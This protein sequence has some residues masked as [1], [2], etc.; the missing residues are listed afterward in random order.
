MSP[1]TTFDRRA[2]ELASRTAAGTQV[3]LLWSKRTG[4]AAV[5]VYD[6]ATGE[7]FELLVRK[8]DNPLDL[9][10]HPYAY[11]A[12]RYATRPAG[13]IGPRSAR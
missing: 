3:T 6:E 12:A 10:Y 4:R 9:Y 13:A 8:D 2:R 7:S 5:V 1:H 11:R